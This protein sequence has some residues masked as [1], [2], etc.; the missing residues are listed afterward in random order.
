MGACFMPNLEKMSEIDKISEEKID[1]ILFKER[2]ALVFLCLI[3]LVLAWCSFIVPFSKNENECLNAYQ[4]FSTVEN[5]NVIIFLSLLCLLFCSV[6]F[7]LAVWEEQN[8]E[9]RKK[10]LLGLIFFLLTNT[11]L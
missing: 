3:S 7:L 1:F 2:I 5:C 10:S 4:Y 6:F 9:K 11:Y 8:K